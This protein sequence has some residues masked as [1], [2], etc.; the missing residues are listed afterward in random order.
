MTSRFCKFSISFCALFI[1]ASCAGSDRDAWPRLDEGFEL[2]TDPRLMVAEETVVVAD[3]QEPQQQQPLS[4]EVIKLMD[5][6]TDQQK[7]YVEALELMASAEQEEK[8]RHWFSAQLELSRLAVLKDALL[9]L[10]QQ[11]IG[12]YLADLESYMDNATLE[13]QQLKP[14]P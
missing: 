4:A 5:E 2:R 14:T 12:V 11:G 8:Q 9:G 7:K 6:I 1:V 13:L 10:N 3:K